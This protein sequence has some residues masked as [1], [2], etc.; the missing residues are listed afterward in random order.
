MQHLSTTAPATRTVL[1]FFLA[2]AVVFSGCGIGSTSASNLPLQQPDNAAAAAAP[3][4]FAS[5]HDDVSADAAFAVQTALMGGTLVQ[6]FRYGS[7]HT[8]RQYHELVLNGV[9][10]ITAIANSQNQPNSTVT[11]VSNNIIG[12]RVPRFALLWVN[13]L[14]VPDNELTDKDTNLII[15]KSLLIPLTLLQLEHYDEAS[16]T[17]QYAVEIGD[18]ALLA[19]NNGS[20]R[21]VS[22]IVDNTTATPFAFAR[23]SL[24]IDM[25]VINGS[26]PIVGQKANATSLRHASDIGAISDVFMRNAHAATGLQVK[27][28]GLLTSWIPGYGLGTILWCCTAVPIVTCIGLPCPFWVFLPLVYTCCIV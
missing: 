9:S 13:Q 26:D 2:S 16:G 22:S 17:I 11:Y 4:I 20:R 24:M 19:G 28:Q 5:G 6:K 8:T 3:D 14:N 1:L 12:D 15:Q 18:T 27:A 10:N 21:P 23:G 25:I 7:D